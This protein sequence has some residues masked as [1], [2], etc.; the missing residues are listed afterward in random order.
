MIY[1]I[2]IKKFFL[3]FLKTT[4][5][6]L[7]FLLF[8]LF[9]LIVSGKFAGSNTLIQTAVV[10]YLAL[11]LNSLPVILLISSTTFFAF[12]MAFDKLYA[13]RLIPILG[14]VSALMLLA[15]FFVNLDF[16]PQPRP[17][18]LT[19]YDKVTEGLINPVNGV[20][21][22]VNKM[23]EDR[24]RSGIL[25]DDNVSFIGSGRVSDKQVVVTTSRV[26]SDGSISAREA[27]LTLPRKETVISLQDTGLLTAAMD[28]YIKHTERMKSIFTLTFT[29]GSILFEILAIIIMCV[30]YFSIVAGVS[31]FL[32][33]QQIKFLSLAANVLV[34]IIGFFGF[35]YFMSLIQVIKFG[36][37]STFGEIL[38]P[39]ILIAVFAGLIG[40]G[41]L[42]LKEALTKKKL[43]G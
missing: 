40:F 13:L 41:L 22:Y 36:I 28:I 1:L 26:I 5:F 20:K 2:S 4:L 6:F 35:Q 34:A 38:L 18:T 29:D 33:D 11:L 8:Y 3:Q 7:V 42:Q 24:I 31:F 14:G 30:G 32:N 17:S 21:V 39:S 25:F 23:S 12:H 19:I 37:K 15:F 27:S 10:N 16:K 43:G 9:G